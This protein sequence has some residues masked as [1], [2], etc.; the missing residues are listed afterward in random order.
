MTTLYV[1]SVLLYLVW[2]F[3]WISWSTQEHAVYHILSFFLYDDKDDDDDDDDDNNNIH[4]IFVYRKNV[5]LI[6][7]L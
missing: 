3:S 1:L 4:V 6:L 5:K 7:I 2:T